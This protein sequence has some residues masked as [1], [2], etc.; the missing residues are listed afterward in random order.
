MDDM[1][2]CFPPGKQLFEETVF[3]VER[4][5]GIPAEFIN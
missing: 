4:Q 1:N 5:E 3:A 2:F